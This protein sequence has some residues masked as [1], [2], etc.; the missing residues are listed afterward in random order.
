VKRE[1]QDR[2][3]VRRPLILAAL[4]FLALAVNLRPEPRRDQRWFP[5]HQSLIRNSPVTL[6]L[7]QL[8]AAPD[9]A[10][11]E[12]DAGT[13]TAAGSPGEAPARPTTTAA[14]R[15]LELDLRAGAYR[16]DA[17]LHA[18][19]ACV[20]RLEA[21]TD[22]GRTVLSESEETLE[23]GQ[24]RVTLAWELAFPTRA[25]EVRLEVT[26]GRVRADSATV[27]NL[28]RDTIP[29]ELEDD[30]G[31]PLHPRFHQLPL[32]PSAR[33][34]LYF[35]DPYSYPPERGGIWVSSRG[36]A[37]AWLRSVRPL[38]YV[39][40]RIESLIPNRVRV[41]L[42][43]RERTFRLE[44]S[45]ASEWL[46]RPEAAYTLADGSRLYSLEIEAERATS[47]RALGLNP[48]DRRMLGA[49]VA[50]QLT[51][52]PLAVASR[53]ALQD[54]WP[55]VREV[56]GTA[57][58]GEE[59]A[60][61]ALRYLSGLAAL[62]LGKR[63]KAAGIF[64]ELSPA[65]PERALARAWLEP[66]ALPP[67]AASPATGGQ[68]PDPAYARLLERSR[69]RL[70]IRRRSIDRAPTAGRPL[71]TTPEGLALVQWE[72]PDRPVPR[73]GAIEYRAVWQAEH[74]LSRP[75]HVFVHIVRRPL[76]RLGLRAARLLSRLPAVPLLALQDDHAPVASELPTTA[77]IPGER[78]VEVRRVHL[79]PE[80]SP[81]KYVV[82]AGVVDPGSGERIPL[83]TRDGRETSEAELGTFVIL[84]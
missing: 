11:R 20:V 46:L 55:G 70:E 68:A 10:L 44:S 52:A 25:V 37:R 17:L 50:F 76:H 58:A 51:P 16:L 67:P 73:G 35:L 33:A 69:Q 13:N 74:P 64:E 7:G 80:L 71:F 5:D 39:L 83:R 78:L 49:F 84:D 75:L 57:G 9:D 31:F 21:R 28:R 53:L 82:I 15:I 63:K 40:L 65:A 79:P 62:H 27:W 32:A 34:W 56:A 54:D 14:M 48:R 77:W 29:G 24:R 22:E 42:G 26:R 3:R 12:L 23:P 4:L 81:G 36:P 72:G 60:A 66:D 41:R 19:T 43:E 47:P 2:R 18:E 6:S 1:A 45:L 38:E 61:A 30:L 8:L 59:A